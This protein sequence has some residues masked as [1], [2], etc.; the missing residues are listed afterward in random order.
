[1]YRM[2]ERAGSRLLGMFV[3]EVDASAAVCYVRNYR[4][5]WQCA[6]RPCEACCDSQGQNCQYII[7]K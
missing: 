4:A 7:C 1:M 3:A 2:L 5:C 6:G